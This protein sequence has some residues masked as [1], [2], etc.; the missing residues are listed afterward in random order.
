M[1]VGLVVAL[2]T[3]KVRKLIEDEV[4]DTAVSLITPFIAYLIAEELHCSGVLAVVVAGLILSH[5]SY[6]LQS[7]SS[8]IFERTIWATIEF[9]LENT[10]FFLIGFQVRQIITDA[11]DSGLPTERVVLVCVAVSLTVMLVRPLWVF[12]MMYLPRRIPGLRRWAS[13]RASAAARGPGRH[14]VGRH[15][16]RGHAGRR[17][18]AAGRHAVPVGADPGRAVVVGSTLLAPGGDPV[19]SCCGASGCAVPT[20]R[21]TA[22]SW[23]P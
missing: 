10:V 7:A 18:R 12:P 4:T 22:C 6:L 5:K 23:P 17:L 21:R 11:A 15:A 3:G 16:W 20:L 14:L 2:V 1:L 13:I 9:L 19:R 8:R